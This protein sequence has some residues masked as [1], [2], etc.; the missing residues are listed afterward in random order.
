MKNPF[1]IDTNLQIGLIYFKSCMDKSDNDFYVALVRYNSGYWNADHGLMNPIT[2][3]YISK[4]T[5]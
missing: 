4:R 1:D 5:E 3:R 2:A